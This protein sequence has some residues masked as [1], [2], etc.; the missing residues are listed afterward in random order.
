MLTRREFLSLS[1][2]G[3]SLGLGA[4]GCQ[5]APSHLEPRSPDAQV[6]RPSE[7]GADTWLPD[8]DVGPSEIRNVLF[9]AIDDL[10]DW[11]GCLSGQP[12]ALTPNIDALAA[13][14][15][16]FE[17]AYCPTPLCCPSRTAVLTGLAPTRTGVYGND[18][19]FRD[20]PTYRSWTTL[21]QHFRAHGYTA[22]SGGKVFHGWSGKL[23]D[24]Q[25]WNRIYHGNAGTPFPSESNRF[26]HGL[27]GKFPSKSINDFLDWYPLKLD[28]NA[29]FDWMTADRAASFLD[30]SNNGP[31]FLACGFFRPHL[32]W[33]APEKYFDLYPLSSIEL[34]VV[35]GND[36]EDI[37][38]A[39]KA[40]A[41]GDFKILHD[42]GL[43]PEA[44][45]AYLA[46]ITFADACVGRVLDALQRS[47]YARNTV[48]VLWA[49]NGFH[50]GEKLHLEKLT[51]WEEAGRTP[52]IISAPG[53]S[54]HGR[55]CSHPVSLLDIF[56]TLVELCGLRAPSLMDGR[57][58]MPLLRNPDQ[59]WP[60][61]AVTTY[62]YKSHS[63][64]SH[65]YRYIRYSGGSEE[66]YDHESDPRE[67]TNLALDPS[68]SSVKQEL[69]EW[70]PKTETPPIAAWR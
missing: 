60:W 6:S 32:P 16:L 59:P 29:T 52:L 67:W 41:G 47:P 25:S 13:R 33:Y 39:G 65:R 3:S 46:C 7:T 19:W 18:E 49:D 8:A 64:R 40:I 43:W 23:A 37:P 62:F 31:F 36:L 54:R 11:V 20:S 69:A 57:S 26:L 24:P 28:D 12:R 38:Q 14:G 50:L 17:R 2:L 70:L 68:L 27:Q 61:P 4:L 63:V 55:R 51:L 15:L 30:Q 21:P 44:V 53:L 5:L 10:N 22:L 1:A 35:Q 9:I 34:P 42:A 45:R 56:P 48:V 58:L 66:L